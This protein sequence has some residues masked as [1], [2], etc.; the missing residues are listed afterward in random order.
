[1]IVSTSEFETGMKIG[2]S[3]A[4]YSSDWRETGLLWER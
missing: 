1:M 3:L 2:D 4:Y